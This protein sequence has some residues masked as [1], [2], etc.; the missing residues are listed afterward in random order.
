MSAR[1]I[2]TT[3]QGAL[4][5]EARRAAVRT[6]FSDK[7][8]G[9]DADQQPLGGLPR[10][11]DG[12]L[13]Q[14]V[15]HLVVDAVGGA[16]QRHLAQRRQIAEAEEAVGRAPGVLRQIDLAF[17]QPLDEFGGR[18][19]DQQHVVGLAAARCPARARAPARR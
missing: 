3:S 6:T 4:R 7:R 8:I 19:I 11:F 1:S 13:L 10:A 2:D 12:V 16:A 14:I 9:A 15:D 18:Q 17:L 5:P